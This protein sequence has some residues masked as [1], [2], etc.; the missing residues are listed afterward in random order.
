MLALK[1]W[2]SQLGF[3]RISEQIRPNQVI[4]SLHHKLP[5]DVSWQL[6]MFS[7]FGHYWSFLHSFLCYHLVKSTLQL[8][9]LPTVVQNPES[10]HWRMCQCWEYIQLMLLNYWN[11]LVYECNWNRLGCKLS[12]TGYFMC[13]YKCLILVKLWSEIHFSWTVARGLL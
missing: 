1:P 2:K 11:W 4:K 13:A 6:K 10:S 3:H 8:N 7:F 5:L 12:R 9:F